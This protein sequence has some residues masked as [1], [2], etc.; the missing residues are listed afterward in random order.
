MDENQ[1]NRVDKFF[2]D[3][4]RFYKDKPSQNLWTKIENKLD[5]EDRLV[6]IAK[7]RKRILF[8]AGVL[9]IMTATGIYFYQS[10]HARNTLAEQPHKTGTN[11]SGSPVDF[12]QFGQSALVNRL[13]LSEETNTQN[14]HPLINHQI[15]YLKFWKPDMDLLTDPSGNT[16]P[17]PTTQTPESRAT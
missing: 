3:S 1:N 16:I 8:A 2:R 12:Q 9:L 13:V 4:L 11:H 14:N 5:K 17:F 6:L 15:P 10:I 7:M